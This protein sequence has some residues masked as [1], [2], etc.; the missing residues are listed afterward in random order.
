MKNS[1]IKLDKLKDKI[2]LNILYHKNSIN[3]KIENKV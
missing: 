2:K 1:N 3:L